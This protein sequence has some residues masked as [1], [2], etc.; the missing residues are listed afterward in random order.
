MGGQPIR[1][2]ELDENFKFKVA[3]Q[4]GAQDITACFSCGTCTAG[5]PIHTVYAELDPRKIARMVNLGMTKR[6]VSSSYIWYCSECWL[7]EQRCPQ[8]V[9][10]SRVWDVLK[11]M[12]AEEG[13]PLP[14]SVN[15]DICSGCGICVILCPY[16]A[17][18]L[19]AENQSRVAHLVSTLCRGCGV[20]ATACPSGAISVKLF[21]D[22]RI[23]TQIEAS[24]PQHSGR[25]AEV[26]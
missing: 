16:E 1:V 9:K 18:E 24:V 7:C 19:R 21:E 8:N 20:C 22:E 15:G 6:A 23:F 13:Y 14:V 4:E 3:A 12:A 17:I 2:S 25:G 10:F 11:N 5:C 26:L